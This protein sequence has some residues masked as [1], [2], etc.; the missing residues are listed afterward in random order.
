MQAA[1]EADIERATVVSG[2]PSAHVFTVLGLN[3]VASMIEMSGVA[4][5]AHP[6]RVAT[7]FARAPHALTACGEYLRFY[8]NGSSEVLSPLATDEGVSCPTAMT[9]GG[10]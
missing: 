2:T 8:A 5:P 6:S 1:M 7:P 4:D 9:G 10:S 3:A